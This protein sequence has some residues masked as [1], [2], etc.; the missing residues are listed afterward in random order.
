MFA[1]LLGER[2]YEKVKIWRKK[3]DKSH[4]KGGAEQKQSQKQGRTD[5]TNG[6]EGVSRRDG[7]K[8]L[9]A[10]RFFS[11]LSPTLDDPIAGSLVKSAGGLRTFSFFL[12]QNAVVLAAAGDDVSVGAGDAKGSGGGKEGS[13][14]QQV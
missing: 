2:C 5:V 7:N 14:G 4:K 10:A 9:S 8:C 11:Q 12:P 6:G 13:A 1:V 3:H